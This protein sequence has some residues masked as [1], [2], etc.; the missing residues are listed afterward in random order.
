M[1]STLI[2][3]ALIFTA[4]FSF[5]QNKE[6]N[7]QW[8][9]QDKTATIATV[10]PDRGKLFVD[11]NYAMFVHWGLYS[12]MGCKWNGKSYYGISEWAM[13]K[14]KIKPQEMVD[15]AKQFNPV[16]FSA[17][18]LVSLAKKS[19][20]KY[21]V[22]TAK[23]H[24][25]FA[26]YDSKI[27]DFNIVAASPYGRDPMKELA[28][29]CAKQGVGLGF[30]YSHVVDWTTPGAS[31]GPKTNAVGDTISFDQYFYSKSLPQINEITSQYGPL[32]LL[33]FDL[34][35]NISKMHGQ[36]IV[37]LVRKNQPNAFINGRIGNNLGDYKGGG[38]MEV[39]QKRIDGFSESCDVTNDSWGW[40]FYDENWK[41]PKLILT[42]LLSIVARGGNYLMNVPPS[43]DGTVPERAEKILL[44]AGKWIHKYPQVVYGAEASPWPQKFSWGDVVRKGNKLYLLVYDWNTTGELWLPGLKSDIKSIHLLHAKKNKLKYE[45]R[46]NAVVIKIPPVAPE[47]FVSVI[48]MELNG[49]VIVDESPTVDPFL[50]TYYSAYFATVEN[51]ILKK[52][53]W[54]EKF[55]EWKTIMQV[56]KWTKDS[57]ATWTFDVLH[58]GDYQVELQYA[59]EGRLAW[60]IETSDGESIQ[61]QQ[62]SSTMYSTQPF[63]WVSFKTAGK[64]KVTVSLLE[65]KFEKESLQGIKLTPIEE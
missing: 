42:N 39:P 23:H 31:M 14:H 22:V 51:C 46:N 32:A 7:D 2:S 53:Q 49:D 62:N 58:P 21:I 44:S 65:G 30:Y 35:G 12:Q 29:E 3:L 10:N 56:E 28:A 45:L 13:Y 38:D 63:G 40:A 59:G 57:K 54:M 27:S 19:G 18:K 6:M 25:G 24:D 41:N 17:S 9:L 15:Y 34:P 1:K 5:A 8:G 16:N 4:L 43:P 37:D 48:E 52:K 64:K 11:G 33:W 20:M 55:G 36:E 60:K 50:P 26:M 61:N 47:K